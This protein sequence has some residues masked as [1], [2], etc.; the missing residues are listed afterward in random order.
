MARKKMKKTTYYYI[1]I[2][3]AGI[4]VTAMFIIPYSTMII[5][6]DFYLECIQNGRIPSGTRESHS[7]HEVNDFITNTIQ[8]RI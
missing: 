2:T 5:P 4:V 6:W 7:C 8:R 1:G 3:I